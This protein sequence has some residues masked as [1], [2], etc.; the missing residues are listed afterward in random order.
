MIKRIEK[1]FLN[2]KGIIQLSIFSLVFFLYSYFYF[3]DSLVVVAKASSLYNYGRSSIYPGIHHNIISQ[4]TRFQFEELTRPNTS[5]EYERLQ[6][7]LDA[8][9]E[10]TT[11][12]VSLIHPVGRLR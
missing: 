7:K 11:P 6:S 10:N 9:L 8:V 5:K 4:S 12:L 3:Y 1:V 2:K